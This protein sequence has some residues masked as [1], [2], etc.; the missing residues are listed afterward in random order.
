MRAALLIA[1]LVGIEFPVF[2]KVT[3]NSMC[4][5]LDQAGSD[6]QGE[7]ANELFEI[8]SVSKVVTGYWALHE[9]G[10]DFRFQTRIYITP[11][12]ADVFDVHIEGGRD[13]FWGRQ[14]THFLFSELNRIGIFQIR[15]LTFDENLIFRWA[16]I[17]DY[18]LPSRPSA[19]EIMK[20]LRLHLTQLRSEY[21][22]TRREAAALG[23]KMAKN[24]SLRVQ[25]VEPR[26]RAD[27]Q[28]TPETRLYLLKSSPLVAYLKEMN[29]VSNNHVADVLFDFLGGAEKFQ[30]FIL[31]D[32]NLSSLDIR[33]VNGSGDALVGRNEQGSPIKEYN[34]AS[35]RAIV[36]IL[37]R[38]DSALKARHLGLKDIMAVSRADESTLR[39]RFD[40]LPN[41]LIAKTG[42]VDPAITLAGVISTARGQVYFGIFM[43]TEGSGDWGTAKDRI[44]LK[45]FELMKK[46]GGR[47]RFAYTPVRF[48]SFDAR[49]RLEPAPPTSPRR[50]SQGGLAQRETLD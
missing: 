12:S 29:N 13:P 25:T 16:V 18:I 39:P 3:L 46:F 22:Q 36:Q 42:S 7:K 27:F 26:S 35:C 44:R 5:V 6:L 43:E 15:H 1:I 31:Q 30:N 45:I 49:S 24:I 28:S 23:I 50:L 34:Q 33:F 40:S 41:S 14:L 2:A 21:P 38:L 20:A 47:R 10:P 37:I 11:V 48:L 4:Y 17:T 32:M 19:E 9:L 8:A